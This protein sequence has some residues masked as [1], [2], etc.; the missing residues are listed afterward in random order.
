LR[1]FYEDTPEDAY[2]MQY[3]YRT[4]RPAVVETPDRVTRR[5]A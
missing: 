3:R 4:E 2:S 1:K 5:A